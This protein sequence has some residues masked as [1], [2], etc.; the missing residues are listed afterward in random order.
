MKDLIKQYMDREVSRREFLCGISAVG[1]SLTTGNAIARELDPF[2][3]EKKSEVLP[4]WMRRM[5]GSGGQLLVQQI[6]AAGVEFI[7]VNPSSGQA[8]IFDALVDE[9]GIQ[10]IKAVHEGA[11]AAMADGYAKASGKTPFVLIARPGLPNC[12]TQMYNSWKDRIPMIVAVDDVS[13]ASRG[14][15]GFEEVAHMAEMTQPITKWHWTAETTAKI[16]DIT[17]RAFKL[18]S[19][20]PSG[21]VFLN[22][23]DNLLHQKAEATIMSQEK[24]SVQMTIRPQK[25]DIEKTAKMLVNAQR[26]LL[27]LGDEVIRSGAENEVLELAELLALPVTRGDA[28]LPHG[29][30]IP[31]PTSHPLSLGEYQRELRYPGEV[32]VMLNLG[33]RLP[34]TLGG[35][36]IKP[37]VKLIQIR[38]DAKDMANVYASEQSIVADVKLATVDLIAAIRSVTS[39]GKLKRIQESRFSEIKTYTNRIRKHYHAIAREK[40]DRTPITFERLMGELENTLDRDTVIVSE[41]DSGRTALISQMSF[42]GKDKHYISNSGLALGWSLPASFGVKL[43]LPDRPVVAIMGDGAFLFSGPQPLWSF[44]RY[45]APITVIVLNNKSYN[46]ERNRIWATGGRQFQ[47]SRDMV[48]YLGDPDVDY[49]KLSVAFGVEAETVKEPESVKAAILRAKR[50]NVEGRPYLLDIHVGRGGIGAL[51]TWHPEYSIADARKR[52]V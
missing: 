27:Y 28:R 37:K 13:Q 14:Q 39:P 51:S 50:A 19:T 21:P 26:P 49:A 25:S 7:F 30:S 5:R 15:D 2:L 52:K 36:Q 41:T 18:A 3:T 34:F 16:P 20:Q 44:A 47:A 1:V 24:F 45:Q 42:G 33:G 6:K 22:F 32:D 23:P 29:W 12:M 11:L 8:P 10:I 4:A 35:L 31:F 48:C 17:R 9:P 46:N 40:W 43:A 38:T